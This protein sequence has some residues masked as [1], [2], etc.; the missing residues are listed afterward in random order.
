[1]FR[2]ALLPMLF[3]ICVSGVG[4]Y[5]VADEAISFDADIRPIFAKHCVA[6]HGGVKQAGGLSFVYRDN[7]FAGGD[8]GAPTVVPGDT[9]ASYLIE[10]VTDSDP[11]IRMPPADHGSPLSQVEI[12]KLS[13]WIK[14]GARWEPP[15]AFVVPHKSDL[16]SVSN[17]SWPR[18][19]IDSFILSRLDRAQL[20]PA[21]EAD[22]SEWLRRV[23]FDLIGLPPSLTELEEFTTDE[24]PAAYEQVVDRLLTSPHFGER[25]AAM[26]LDLARYADTT[27]YERDPHRDIW[28]Y[29]DWVIRSFNADMPFDQ[30]T[31][32]Q[33]AGDLLEN[34]TMDDLVATAFHRNTQTNTEGGTDDEEFRISAVIDRVNTTWQ[35]WQATTFGCT[36]CHAHPY[37][38]FRHEDYY[39]FLAILNNTRD[40]DIDE[41][42][43]RLNVPLSQ[44]DN[45]QARVILERKSELLRALHRLVLPLAERAENWHGLKI[46]TAT[47]TGDTVLQVLAGVG[48]DSPTAVEVE[49]AATMGSKF[50][51]EAN[52]PDGVKTLAALRIDA[53]LRDAKAARKLPEPGFVVSQLNVVLMTPEH[54]TPLK[55]EFDYVFSDEPDPLLDPQDSLDKNP[56]GWGSYSRQWYP[57]YTVFIL[58]QPVPVPTGSRIRIEIEQ[59]VG[60]SGDVA[61]VLNRSTYAVS[62]SAN[63]NDLIR[64]SDFTKARHQFAS[65]KDKSQQISCISI[66]TTQELAP[67]RRRVTHIFERGLWLDKGAE[68]QSGLPASLA[69]ESR[70]QINRLDMARWLVSRDN[71]LTARVM[72]NRIWAEL[73]GRGIVETVD[74]FGVSGTPPSHQELL[75]YLAVRFRDDYGWSLKRLLKEIVLSATYRQTAR[76][77]PADTSDLDNRLLSH[78]PRERLSAEMVRD[79][80]LMLSGRFSE[81]QFG[82][83]VM[84]PQPEGIWRSVYS[85]EKWTTSADSDKYRRAVYT[86]WKRTSG[87]P[88]MLTFDAPSRE[89]CSGQRITTNTPLQALVTLN[90]E[91]F[92]ELAEGL[93]TKMQSEGGHELTDRITWAYRAATST[94]PTAEII[95]RLERLYENA[96]GEYESESGNDSV[97][98]PE[99]AAL[100]VVASTILNLD[101]ALTK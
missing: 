20:S 32:S 72:V 24:N 34:P 30:F 66:P 94:D 85:G 44:N 42:F 5:A 45:T 8:S 84:P 29:R 31:I 14:L 98:K 39:R 12:D 54:Q 55:L 71:P 11:D 81:K 79:Q 35:V 73:F 1:M 60:T 4:R 40:S 93:A 76:R 6:C 68:V 33:L 19:A 91:A 23:S 7:V 47:S 82:P 9:A 36:Q 49:G 46:D 48:S 3:A 28:P 57:Q 96:L 17:P 97:S 16:P 18:S 2:L 95:E 10:R 25:W 27:G 62:D 86:F 64:S 90:D 13:N 43:P 70:D 61:L 56:F 21:P 63:W 41:E 75:D 37:E 101:E 65:L 83:P 87:Y 74:D 26:W 77:A 80:A 78:G 15:W 53:L 92:L 38:A 67:E 22:R 99:H 89:V 88:A 58:K 50:T 52:M 100:V 51:V 69:P 59:N